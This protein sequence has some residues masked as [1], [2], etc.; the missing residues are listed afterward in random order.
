MNSESISNSHILPGE[1]CDFS[2]G[3]AIFL[4]L[5]YPG[6]TIDLLN[7]ITHHI[8]KMDLGILN[9]IE[10]RLDLQLRS[11]SW[12]VQGNVCFAD[13]PDL[14]PEYRTNFHAM[15]LWDYYYAVWHSQ[16][17]WNSIPG[18]NGNLPLPH[19][20]YFWRTIRFGTRLREIH[21]LKTGH[22]THKIT[23]SDSENKVVQPMEVRFVKA[24][25]VDTE[26]RLF[27]NDNLYL[28]HISRLAWEYQL[29]GV[30]PLPRWFKEHMNEPVSS[31]DLEILA[32]IIESVEETYSIQT[33]LDHI[34]TI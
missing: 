10:K 9:K 13:D 20:D 18:K 26:G 24:A 32:G 28:D 27:L 5:E 19:P 7:Q 17:Y 22:P 15:D 11:A 25:N 31:H 14:R 34:L 29:A 3:G 1:I 12:D 23:L 6:K 33:I 30:E 4:F 2:S 21:L 16:Q 8:Q